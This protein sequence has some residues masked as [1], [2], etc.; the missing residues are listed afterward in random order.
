MRLGLNV[1]MFP[2]AMYPGAPELTLAEI[3]RLARDAEALGV[4][5][6]WMPEAPVYREAIVPLSAMAGATRTIRLGTGILP[7]GYRSPLTVARTIAQLDELAEGRCLLGLG[8]GMRQ[9]LEQQGIATNMPVQRLREYVTVIKRFLA[10]ETVS[11]RGS[12][13]S[14]EATNLGF[15]APRPAVPIFLGSYNEQ[16]L[17]LV[18]EMADGVILPAL[19]MRTWLDGAL[20]TLY[21][22]AAKA[23]RSS[24]DL[25]VTRYTITSVHADADVARTSA[26]HLLSYYIG[27]PHTDRVLKALGFFPAAL[28]LRQALR[29]K[30]REAA[31]PLVN[32]DIIACFAVAGTV[33]QCAAQLRA[34]DPAKV[35]VHT[36]LPVGPSPQVAISNV[37]QLCRHVRS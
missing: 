29:E 28:K 5:T 26:R 3:I 18:G 22:A 8:I 35:H 19:C 7:I 13:Y 21:D 27:S 11:F 30:G 1:G 2:P 15:T 37:L 6:V 31:L 24:V 12:F 33:E 14:F 4:E 10:G 25:T 20:S 36:L 17:Q 23:G 32:D 16:S 9:I 34:F